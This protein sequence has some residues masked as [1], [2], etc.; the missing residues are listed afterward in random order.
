MNIKV[1][2]FLLYFGIALFPFQNLSLQFG[3][4]Y[5][6][7]SIFLLAFIFLFNLKIF[8]NPRKIFVISKKIGYLLLIY[9]TIQLVLFFFNETS[10]HRLISGLVWFGGLFIIFLSRKEIT[11]DFLLTYKIIFLVILFSSFVILFEFLKY[12][13][14]PRAFFTEPSYA[15][16]VLFSMSAGYIGSL[17]IG[18]DLIIKNKTLFLYGFYFFF[19]AL[20]TKSLHIFSFLAVLTPIT[21]IFLYDLK[22]NFR[23]RSILK[24]SFLVFIIIIFVLSFA[25]L[26]HLKINTR[27]YDLGGSSQS[28]LTWL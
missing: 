26:Y 22:K 19:V 11:V 24:F 18:K 25:D 4:I 9:F 21:L 14:R 28:L 16:L 12:D 1:Q 2:S 15:G 27:F 5:D 13:F 10:L 20:L 17:M 6:L 3:A 7:S 23:L 8:F